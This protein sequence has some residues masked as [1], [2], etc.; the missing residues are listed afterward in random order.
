MVRGRRGH[1]KNGTMSANGTKRTWRK[2]GLRSA[3]DPKQT[4]A[5]TRL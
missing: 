1:V 2:A 4:A 3:F 5:L